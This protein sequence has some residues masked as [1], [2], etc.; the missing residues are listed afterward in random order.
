[1]PTRDSPGSPA[2]GDPAGGDPAA[3]DP[4][5]GD[6]AAGDPAAR[7]PDTGDPA[8]G[9][10]AG[11]GGGLLD[12]AVNELYQSD[13]EQFMERRTALA[14]AAK[15]SGS[16][17]VAKQ[18]AA[19]RKPTRSAY[20]VNM[21]ARRDPDRLAELADLGTDLRQAQRTVDAGQIRELTRRRRHLVDG[22]VRRVFEI[23]GEQSPSATLRDE[24]TSTLTAALS[25]EQ[26]AHDIAAGT[27]VTPV[28]WDGMGGDLSGGGVPGLTLVGPPTKTGAGSANAPAGTRKRARSQTR[29]GADSTPPTPSS[30][31]QDRVREAEQRRE[32]ERVAAEQARDAAVGAAQDDLDQAEQA[33]TA[34]TDE[35]GV[36][37]G[38]MHELEEHIADARLSVDEARIVV[39]RAEMRQ[40]RAQ[41]ALNRLLPSTGR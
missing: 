29:A 8:A 22:I 25:D 35:E 17:A 9:D 34:A 14:A 18:I 16:A 19:L 37:V 1:M 15:K 31:K 38:R 40:R 36:R 3:G 11:S 32:Q 4:A 26:I 12:S 24:V 10:P 28:R 13:P 39:R 21:L 33:L 23:T 5:A 27:L 2:N 7:D 6:P 41:E 30:S 20:A